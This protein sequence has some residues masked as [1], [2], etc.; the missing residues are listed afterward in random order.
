MKCVK[1]KKKEIQ[2]HKHSE[3][4]HLQCTFEKCE[5]LDTT[6]QTFKNDRFSQF[7]YVMNALFSNQRKIDVSFFVEA[8][9]CYQ[10]Q[11]N[12]NNEMS[13]LVSCGVHLNQEHFIVFT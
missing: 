1:R 8:I 9:F 10:Q 6:G 12:S 4:T 2:S 7:Q 11:Q 5:H 3:R 13:Y